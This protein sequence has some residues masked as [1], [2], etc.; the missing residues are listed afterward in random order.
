MLGLTALW[1]TERLNAADEPPAINP[2]GPAPSLREDAVP[3]YVELSDGSVHPGQIYLTRDKRLKLY[4]EKLRR[5]REVPLRVVKQIE[6]KVKKE[7]M[8]KQ[9]KFKELASSEK[10]FTGRT[11]P[12][13]EYVHAITLRDDRTITGPLS[14]IVYVQP[15]MYTPDEPGKYRTPVKPL[16]F[17][18]HKRQKGEIGDDLKSLHYVKLIKLGEDAL[19]EGRRRVAQQRSRKATSAGQGGSGRPESR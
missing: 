18:L 2:F 5:Q 6:C 4:D 7:W 3:G 14:G 9:W 19:A 8:E 11:Y 10:M 17:L 13:R 16:H 12:A 1:T 15:Y